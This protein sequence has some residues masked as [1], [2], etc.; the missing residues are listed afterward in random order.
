MPAGRIPVLAA[1]GALAYPWRRL[2]PAS[3]AAALLWASAYALLGVV[4]GGIFDSPLLAMLVATMLVL[5]VGGVTNLVSARRRREP[6][7]T[8]PEPEHCESA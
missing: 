5:A 3:V 6:E 8:A 4:S 1:A 7:P 2:V